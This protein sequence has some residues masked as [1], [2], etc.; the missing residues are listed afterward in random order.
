MADDSIQL[1]ETLRVEPGRRLPLLAGHQ[2]RLRASCEALG[3]RWPEALFKQ[4]LPAYV[5]MLDTK[6]THRLRILLDRDGHHQLESNL[7][8]STPEP[9][10]LRLSQAPRIADALW[11]AHKSTH[12]PWYAAAQRWLDTQ[13]DIFDI[14]YCNTQDQLCEGSRCNIYVQDGSGAWLT[15]PLS[16]GL[17][18]GVQR[19]ALLEQGLV[20]VALL[21]RQDLI[22][23][24]AL[25]VSNALRGWL[26]ARLS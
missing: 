21:T 13:R 23:S 15:P 25:R 7:L 20:R 3:Y 11:L 19:Q 9:V 5:S 10:R 2:R 22:D 26:D 6:A 12:R 24:P 17:L 16:C 14:V 8:P 1:I 4:K 18:P